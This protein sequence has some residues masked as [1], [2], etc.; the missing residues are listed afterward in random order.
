MA[1]IWSTEALAMDQPLSSFT[2][3]ITTPRKSA[4]T[5]TLKSITAVTTTIILKLLMMG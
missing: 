5:P 2:T 4:P 1:S 3:T